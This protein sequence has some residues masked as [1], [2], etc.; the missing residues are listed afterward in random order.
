[1][2]QPLG[3][4][5]SKAEAAYVAY[6]FRTHDFSIQ[7]DMLNLDHSPIKSLVDVT[8]QLLD[9]QV[10]IQRDQA[11]QRTATFQFLDP[12]HALALDPDS[13]WQGPYFPDRMVRVRHT[14]TVPGLGQVV[15]TPF[16]GPITKVSRDGELI[17][18]EC[19]DKASLALT[20]CP[21]VKCSK[22]MNAVDAIRRIMRDGAGENRFRLPEGTKRNLH[23]VYQCGWHDDAAPWVVAQRIAGQL[24]MQLLYSCDGYLT[25]R[26]LPS[27]PTVTVTGASLTS[28]P[29]V[30]FDSS[31]VVNIV[32]VA[33]TLAP[34]R[35][36]NRNRDARPQVERNPTK[37]TATAVA[38]ASHPLAP[39]RL[40]RNGVPRYLPENIEDKVYKSMA[41]ARD[42][43]T[44]TLA[45]GLTLTTGVSFDM[46]PLFH[47]DVGDLVVAQTPK[48]KV[49]VRLYE[50]SIP[51][52]VSGDMSVGVQRRVSLVRRPRVHTTKTVP[53]PTKKQRKQYHKDLAAWR[54]KH[55]HG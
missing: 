52:S 19:Q 18:V 5:D 1:M 24:N 14:V 25:L 44:T 10:N 27:Q 39:G 22:G 31:E 34:P 30:D 55:H 9:G 45:D 53:K 11:V 47:L 35:Q 37:I 46:V 49:T 7:V 26:K 51:L 15:A 50:G 3:L 28:E 54:K 32:R 16:I 36:R 48:G 2:S 43:A 38:A 21:P 12:D 33:G 42:L 17:D 41:Q 13:P 20:G 23:K 6:L 29:A 4:K 8:A 40:G